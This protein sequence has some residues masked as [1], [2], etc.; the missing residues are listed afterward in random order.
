MPGPTDPAP[1]APLRRRHPLTRSVP[2]MIGIAFLA[3]MLLLCLG[4]LPWTLARVAPPADEPG[5]TGQPRYNDG[6][7][8]SGRLPPW[9]WGVSEPDEVRRCNGLV[10]EQNVA[11]IAAA[12]GVPAREAAGA[13]SGPIA[14]DLRRLWPQNQHRLTFLLGTDLLGRSLLVRCLTGGG[15]SLLI[16][17]AA[18]LVS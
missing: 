18:A 16:G 7:P 10:S 5:G 12:H 15:I 17:L 14:A 2:G 11:R 3:A 9:W 13:T 6:R 8:A 1:A 4:T